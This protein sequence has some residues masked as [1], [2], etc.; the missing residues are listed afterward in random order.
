[1][2]TKQR[3][4]GRKVKAPLASPQLIESSSSLSRLNNES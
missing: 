1:M 4:N 3:N 2:K